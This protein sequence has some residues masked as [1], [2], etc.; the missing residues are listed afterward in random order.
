MG[1]GDLYTMP[2]RKDKE[3]EC[4]STVLLYTFTGKKSLKDKKYF[5]S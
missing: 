3:Y 5:G 4:L 2:K 1:G